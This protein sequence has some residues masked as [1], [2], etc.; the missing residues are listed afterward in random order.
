M[1][2]DYHA[3][4]APVTATSHTR[5]WN[6]PLASA[7]IA[8]ARRTRGVVPGLLGA[9]LLLSALCGTSPLHAEPDGATQVQGLLP[10]FETR[11]DEVMALGDVVGLA[12]AVVEGDR[13]LLRRGYGMTAVR[14][15]EPVTPQTV[16]RTA[17]LS[18]TFAGALT[19]LLVEAQRLSWNAP[20][21]ALL[22][23]FA[24]KDP[25]AAESLTVNDLLAHRVGLTR[26]AFDLDLEAD[27][28]YPLLVEKLAEAPI[29]CPVGACYAYQNIAF[30]LIGDISFA[31]TGDFY[32]RE[33]ERRLFHPLGMHN[34]TYGRDAL[35]ASDS[36][37]RPHVRRGRGWVSLRPKEN[38]YR[39][40]P[41]AG[42]NASV[43]DLAQ[44]LI[45]QLGHRPDVLS[46][47]VLADLHAPQVETRRETSGTRW[48]RTRL[49]DAH[50]ARGWRVFDY[51][52][53]TVVFHGGAVQGYRAIIG[54]LPER[55]VGIAMLWNCESALPAG[56]FPT[57]M[58]S[59]LGLPQ[60]DWIELDRHRRLLAGRGRG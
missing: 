41:A 15:G 27:Q 54:F 19:G 18:K 58:D 28:P 5:P 16:F 55:Q 39:V 60:H 36:W 30:S 2:Q 57:F 12:L 21:A 22:P 11:V 37:A 53:E 1:G 47:E 4:P 44:W 13:V 25:L 50:Y 14:G 8:A 59:V 49:R 51:A 29:V 38:Y 32:Y 48:R 9:G 33:V 3:A 10:E 26:H 42:V 24:L 7:S 56:L 6:P 31:I 23:G 17:S 46:A 52:G 20:V 45:A 34:A 35:E 40:P 43:D